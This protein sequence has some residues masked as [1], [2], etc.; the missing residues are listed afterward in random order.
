MKSDASLLCL[1]VVT[2]VDP[3]PKAEALTAL[4]IRE[5]ETPGVVE[6]LPKTPFCSQSLLGLKQCN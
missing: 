2:N 4:L 1:V 3:L 6:N 5:L